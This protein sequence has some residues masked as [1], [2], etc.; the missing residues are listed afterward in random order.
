M[1]QAE[2][3]EIDSENINIDRNSKD[4][5]I[6]RFLGI[7]GDLGSPMGLSNDFAV[8]VI[9][10]VGNYQEVYERN[11]GQPFDLERGKNALW[12]DGCLMYSPPFK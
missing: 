5:A 11:L 6:K 1:I 4:G 8:R 10:H 12:R 7:E 9:R 3:L 2:E